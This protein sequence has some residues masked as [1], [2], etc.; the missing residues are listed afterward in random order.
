L[1][2]GSLLEERLIIYAEAVVKGRTKGFGWLA[3]VLRPEAGP[4]NYARFQ[5]RLKT[6]TSSL[7]IPN[8]PGFFLTS[9]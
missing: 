3:K 2:R 8:T 5:V 7:M 9:F 6:Q 4:A 1:Q